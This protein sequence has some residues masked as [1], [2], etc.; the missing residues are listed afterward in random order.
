MGVRLPKTL[1][2]DPELARVA[3]GLGCAAGFRLWTIARHLTRMADG[4]S[5]VSKHALKQALRHYRI[6]YTRQHLNRLMRSGEGIF[7]NSNRHTLYIRSGSHVARCLTQQALDSCPDL[8]LNKPGV[9]DVLLS[10]CGTLEGWQ[11]MIYAGWLTHRDNPTISRETL[12]KLFNRTPETL[13]R[14]EAIHLDNNLIV[15]TNF[16]QCASVETALNIMP[17]RLNTYVANTPTGEQLR[18]IWQLPNSY[19]VKTIKTH[20]HRGQS[21]TVRKA[22]NQ[23][24]QHPANLWRGG[25]LVCKLYFDRPKLAQHHLAEHGG[26]IYLWRGENRHQHGIFEVTD[27]GWSET[28]SNERASFWHER[29][30]KA[31]GDFYLTG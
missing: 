25:S 18:L 15:R 6:V 7:W 14:W 21:K 4:S 23:Q 24:L 11:A 31:M 19:T 27:N 2:V 22:V 9:Q 1:R 20:R 16:A 30:I 3:V 13:R 10:P 26:F 28:N 29:V 8:L 5:K 12:Q 17:E